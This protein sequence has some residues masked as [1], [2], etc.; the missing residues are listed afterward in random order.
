MNVVPSL[1]LEELLPFF[2]LTGVPNLKELPRTPE[3]HSGP[4]FI[5]GP[6]GSLLYGDE[7]IKQIY[8][9]RK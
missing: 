2:N 3:S 6:S 9:R 1:V 5:P 7:I 8:V 4:I